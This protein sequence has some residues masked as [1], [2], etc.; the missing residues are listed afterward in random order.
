[1]APYAESKK[2]ANVS[3]IIDARL[4]API[5]KYLAIVRAQYQLPNH[6][7]MTRSLKPER[8]LS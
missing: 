8:P 1:M 4:K 7:Q 6:L 2:E 5:A 3:I